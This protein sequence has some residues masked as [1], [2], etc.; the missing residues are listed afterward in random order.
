MDFCVGSYGVF[1]N[2]LFSVFIVKIIDGCD[3]DLVVW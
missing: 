1:D 2:R 3:F